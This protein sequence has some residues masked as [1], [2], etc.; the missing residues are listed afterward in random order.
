MNLNLVAKSASQLF[1]LP[2]ICIKLQD[3]IYDPDS[4]MSDIAQLI[5]IDPSLSARLLKIANS[6]FYSFPSQID[7][8][9]RAITLIG[10]ADL[11]S[12][13]LATS[14]P[15]TFSALDD[16][17]HIDI[18]RYWRHSVTT[19]LIGRFLAQD[20]KLTHSESFF[21]A[22]LFHNLGKLVILEQMPEQYIEVKNN[23]SEEKSPW[24]AE[25]AVLG[26]TYAEVGEA[27]LNCWSMPTHL[28]DMVAHQH[29]PASAMDQKAASIIHIASRAASQIEYQ[30]MIG[31][32]FHQSI[33]PSAWST[34]G[35]VEEQMQVAITMA[36]SNCHAMLSMMKLKPLPKP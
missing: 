32:N 6:S 13:A 30:P 23:I 2:E 15:D 16:N 1:T 5:A 27:L 29:A 31:F 24:V 10:T 26:H 33:A 36:Q 7:S 11:Y 21:L 25:K 3:L 4:S 19:G 9:S 22:G 34:T 14:T 20:L 28:L 12:L 35:L 17:E 8:L 18:H